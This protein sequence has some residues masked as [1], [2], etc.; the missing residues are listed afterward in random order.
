M[1]RV[2]H[3][4]AAAFAAFVGLLAPTGPTSAEEATIKQR[5]AI[6]DYMAPNFVLPES[7]IWRFSAIKPYI[8]GKKL[9]CGEVNF[10]SAMRQYVG[11]HRFYVTL[12]DNR[13]VLA[14]IENK[15]ADPSGKL[16]AR[17]DLLCGK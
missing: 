5:D 17:L 15:N 13:V 16:A 2:P 8:G 3:V 12:D 6:E 4:I 14:Q 10:Q 7:S 11:F 1:R 9:V